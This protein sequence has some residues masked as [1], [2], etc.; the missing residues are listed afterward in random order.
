MITTR[1]LL[2]TSEPGAIFS[3]G[4]TPRFKFQ[5]RNRTA[6]PIRMRGRVDALA[7]GTRAIAG[8][9]WMPDVYKIA[10]LPAIAINV[11]IAAQGFQ[12]FE[13]E[14]PLAPRMG[15]Q[16][17][18]V[19]LGAHGRRFLTSYVRTFDLTDKPRV[20]YPQ[21]DLENLGGPVLNKLGV[22]AIRH[23]VAFVSPDDKAAYAANLERI[24][25]EMKDLHENKVTAM[26]EFGEGGAPMPLGRPR[27]HLTDEGVMKGGKKDYVWLPDQDGKFEAFV[28][29]IATKYGW[30]HGPVTGM[31]L[32]NEPWEG[33]SISGWQADIPRYQE[34][35]RRINS[36]VAAARREG[37]DV[38]VGGADSSSNAWDK[39]FGDGIQENDEFLP[40]FD[41]V[42][43]HYQGLN[44]P[45]LHPQWRD[46]KYHRGR[47]KV[48]DTE[49][50][51]ANTDDR[52][53]GAFASFRAAGYD[54]SLGIYG[55]NVAANTEARNR[56]QRILT[57]QGEQ[58]VE[59]PVTAWSAAASVA[60]VQKFIG[61]RPFE[62][63]LFE[64]GLP[65][66][67]IFGGED[68]GVVV[69]L[70][71]LSVV[72]GEDSRGT[73]FRTV[74]SQNELREKAKLRAEMTRTTKPERR[75]EIEK[76]LDKPMLYS[77]A[78][79][80]LRAAPQYGLFDYYGNP[81]SHADGNIEIPLD[82]RGFYLKPSGRKG[83]MKALLAALKNARVAGIEP[84][85]MIPLDFTAPLASKPSL[86]VRVT[87]VLPQKVSG[88]FGAQM[89][90]IELR[91]P[92][93]LTLAAGETRV[94]SLPVVR[95]RVA[96]ANLYPLALRFDG[97]RDGIAQH[98]ETMRVNWIARRTIKIDGDLNDWNGVLP[99]TI[100]GGDT[101]RSLTEAAWLP[102]VDFAAG[103]TTGLATGYVAY[104]D[105][106]FYFGAKIADDTPDA[107]TLRFASRDDSEF[108]YPAVS[109]QTDDKNSLRALLQKSDAKPDDI[110][111]MQSP[112]GDGRTANRWVN[113]REA[114]VMAFRL[115]PETARRPNASGRAVC[116]AWRQFRR[117]RH[118]PGTAN[119]R[120]QT[121]RQRNPQAALRWRLRDF[122]RARRRA[123]HRA[124]PR[125]LV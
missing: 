101:A 86:R 3:P 8:D 23:G 106:Y 116:R 31:D 15:G 97:G 117:R 82:T 73:L 60:A 72:T 75:A 105:D 124:R 53:A 123:P 7:Y 70:G 115:R 28:K 17:L 66:V 114:G 43:I 4:Q 79:L 81:I 59:T 52:V 108:F 11:D 13:I 46:R 47:V 29:L 20:Q 19:D 22:Q 54:R 27:P 49:S 33:I 50:W 83:S 9:I 111:Q 113:A 41:F 74:R 71:D 36:A 39:Y 24:E 64:N 84:L 100:R 68:D 18:I 42:S 61:E 69:V 119:A 32:W 21:Q 92:P 56:T 118:E 37:A 65:W 57:A 80:T 87:N 48:W 78:K 5:I 121:H 14:A 89:D 125:R 16:A 2:E 38:L 120:R 99:Q 25:R 12:N 67:Y 40:Y 112:N 10:D 1:Y 104:D 98:D 110:T 51:V 85:E 94:L 34:I 62:R 63:V 88:T 107:G 35:T 95:A 55:G 103:Q 77:G 76:L 90:G 6:Q 44:A 122:Q 45:A 102:M 26:I 93:R 30:P 58:T 96:P 91:V 109:Y